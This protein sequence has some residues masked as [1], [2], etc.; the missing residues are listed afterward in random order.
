MMMSASKQ[1]RTPPCFHVAGEHVGLFG[2]LVF[3]G[4][5]PLYLSTNVKL[6]ANP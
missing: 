3:E 2:E 5:M 1:E 6:F 4:K